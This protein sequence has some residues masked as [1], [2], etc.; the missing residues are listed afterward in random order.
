ME[1]MVVCALGIVLYYSYLTVREILNDLKREGFLFKVRA[2]EKCIGI[3][4]T[5]IV[6][7]SRR[8]GRIGGLMG[9]QFGLLGSNSAGSVSGNGW[10]D[11]LIGGCYGRSSRSSSSST[12]R[13]CSSLAMRHSPLLRW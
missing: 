10:A 12:R 4:R 13:A 7:N 3:P 1:P 8:L 11:G 2:G 9:A 6:V 5:G